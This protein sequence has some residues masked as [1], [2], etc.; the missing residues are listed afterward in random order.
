MAIIA[1]Y[2]KCEERS[3]TIYRLARNR[4]KTM[5]TPWYNAVPVYTGDRD[6]VCMEE[7]NSTQHEEGSVVI[8]GV[9]Q[10]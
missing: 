8:T 5:D 1:V 9:K 3:A 4:G 7:D 2:Y 10:K 6:D